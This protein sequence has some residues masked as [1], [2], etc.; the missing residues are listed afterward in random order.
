MSIFSVTGLSWRSISQLTRCSDWLIVRGIGVLNRRDGKEV[1]VNSPYDNMLS[2]QN[3][4]VPAFLSLRDTCKLYGK[5]SSSIPSF[6]SEPTHPSGFSRF[7]GAASKEENNATDRAFDSGCAAVVC[8][9]RVSREAVQVSGVESELFFQGSGLMPSP[10]FYT[11][12]ATSL[13]CC[14]VTTMLRQED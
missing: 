9:T 11:A 6:L 2:V 3:D 8:G 13:Q 10:G 5:K 12:G 4:A 1:N 14:T 7:W